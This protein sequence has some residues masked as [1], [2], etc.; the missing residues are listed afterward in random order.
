MIVYMG[1]VPKLVKIIRDQVSIP[2]DRWL[3]D[4]YIHWEK[5]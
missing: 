2:T 3:G 1:F 4:L 5:K